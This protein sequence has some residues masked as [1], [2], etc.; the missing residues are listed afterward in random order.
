QDRGG[1]SIIIPSPTGSS[2]ADQEFDSTVAIGRVRHDF[3]KSFI[4]F[5][6]TDRENQGDSHNR[7]FGPDFQWKADHYAI[8]GQF[9]FSASKTPNRTDLA[10]EWDG[11]K[12]RSHAFFLNYQYN[13]P[14]WDFY[15][16]A[17]HYGDE[18]RADNGFLPEVGY[19][20]DYGELGRTFR[21]SGFFNRVRTF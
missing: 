14:K 10:D 15:T 3:G 1:G 18:F 6:F 11:R 17:K 2:L 8:T 21:P 4:S 13:D 12:L 20:S 7:V 5:L 9:P 19:R 16:E